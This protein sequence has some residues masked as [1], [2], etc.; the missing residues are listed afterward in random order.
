[1][2]APQ[3]VALDA[4]EIEALRSVRDKLRSLEKLTHSK[5]GM[6]ELRQI[7]HAWVRENAGGEVDDPDLRAAGEKVKRL[8]KLARIGVPGARQ[9]RGVL[10]SDIAEVEAK[11][12]GEEIASFEREARA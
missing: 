11:L 2:E 12:R 7:L 4:L 9:L 8:A 10:Q 1:M 3:A 6:S 5:G